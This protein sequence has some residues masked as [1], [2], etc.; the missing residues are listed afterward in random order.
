[1]KNV[2]LHD[3]TPSYNPRVGPRFFADD[4]DAPGRH[5]TLSREESHHL[6]HVMRLRVGA[7]VRVFDGRGGE[8]HARVA[9]ADRDR[10]RLEMGGPVA[11]APE[12][13]TSLVLAQAVLKGDRM[14]A[15]V[16]DATMMGVAVVQPITT[17]HTTVPAR[18]IGAPA[19]ER[20][21]RVAI[22]SAKQCGRAVVPEVRPA[23]GLGVVA[24]EVAAGVR[25]LLT[26]PRAEAEA[27]TRI[28]AWRHAARAGG[29]VVAVGPEGG[30]SRDEIA[31]ATA[32]G[33]VC[34][35]LGATTLRADAAAL[36]ALAVVRY[37]WEG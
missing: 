37:A 10:V 34:W 6:L 2:A 30:W 5:A 1:M 9:A 8:W 33:F 11:P 16:R 13:S 35:S 17:T 3:L 25:L 7:E 20:W 32:A 24:R 36:A 18:A 21:R 29:A 23:A 15:V 28:D 19:I 27:S 31:E 12:W 4:L 22:A 14:E 26:E